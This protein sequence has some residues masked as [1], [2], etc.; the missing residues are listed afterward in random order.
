MGGGGGVMMAQ[1]GG[2][3]YVR[4]MCRFVNQFTIFDVSLLKVDRG[5]N[6]ARCS[7]ELVRS[8]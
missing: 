3:S 7:L 6:Y 4:C 2:H 8:G 5:R 1:T